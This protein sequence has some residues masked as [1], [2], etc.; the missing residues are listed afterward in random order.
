M[1]GK[2]II[3][4][5]MRAIVGRSE[6]RVKKKTGANTEKQ[7]IS[8]ANKYDSWGEKKGEEMKK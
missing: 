3:K 1:K 2:K 6:G 8:R 7:R 5:E 4:M